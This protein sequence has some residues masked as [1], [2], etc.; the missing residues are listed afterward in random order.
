MDFKSEH[1]LGRSVKDA[2]QLASYA[3]VS[4]VPRVCENY[5]ID[6]S[7]AVTDHQASSKQLQAAFTFF[8]FY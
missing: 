2:P 4:L 6:I 1:L 5:P 7:S 8:G 3:K